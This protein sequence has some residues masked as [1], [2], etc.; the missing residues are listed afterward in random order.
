MAKLTKEQ[1]IE[2]CKLRIEKGVSISELAKR[3]GILIA[4]VYEYVRKYRMHGEEAF[5]KQHRTFPL[6]KKLEIVRRALDGESKASLAIECNLHG[7]MIDSWL[8]RYEKDGYNGLVDRKRGRPPAMKRKKT[9]ID[10]IADPK[11]REIALLKQRNHE[12]EAENA[13]LK[14]LKAL[15]LQRNAQQTRKRR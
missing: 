4:H 10:G 8:K 6:E 12:L 2:M 1:K 9:D 7:G 13:A 3:Y 11:D 5:R 14:K 15:V